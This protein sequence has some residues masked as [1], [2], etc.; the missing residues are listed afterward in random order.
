MKATARTVAEAL[1]A[2]VRR[3]VLA[4]AAHEVSHG[5]AWAHAGFPAGPARVET[6]LFGG[7]RGG[8]C[9]NGASGR[10]NASN[11]TGFLVGCAAGRAGQRLVVARLLG[12]RDGGL[13]DGSGS[14]REDFRYS[15]RYYRT[16]LSFAAAERHATALLRP[17]LARVGALT[18]RLAVAGRLSRSDFR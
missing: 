17:R 11:A 2:G 14:D 18:V 6:G 3:D 16:G 1:D 12:G 7:A 13:G 4:L 15:E 8:W 5:L 9:K 10:L